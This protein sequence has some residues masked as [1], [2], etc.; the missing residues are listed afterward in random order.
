MTGILEGVKVLD[1][2]RFIAGNSCTKILGDMGADVIRVEDVGGGDDR[3]AAPYAP[4]GESM[5]SIPI[6]CNKRGITLNIRDEEGRKILDKLLQWADILVENYGVSAKESL[7]LTGE[8]V[9]K[10]NEKIIHI[11]ISCFG[12]DDSY[13]DFVGLIQLRRRRRGS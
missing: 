13:S 9:R 3:V 2:T 6:N 4:N 1:L 7:R 5:M 11:S 12:L 10:V 8:E